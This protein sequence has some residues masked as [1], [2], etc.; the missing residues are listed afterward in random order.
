MRG[1]CHGWTR[2][3]RRK[4]RR[5]GDQIN[6]KAAGV[7]RGGGG[8]EED[9]GSTVHTGGSSRPPPRKS[10]FTGCVWL[11]RDVRVRVSPGRRC[12]HGN[13]SRASGFTQPRH[14]NAKLLCSSCGPCLTG[15]LCTRLHP[16][17]PVTCHW[18]LPALPALSS[19]PA[20]VSWLTRSVGSGGFRRFRRLS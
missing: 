18:G 17:L 8:S 3:Q 15:D 11:C 1:Q 13:N 7:K 20:A 4:I 9:P 12:C 19:P 5:R 2:Q 10:S 6:M 14:G 16:S